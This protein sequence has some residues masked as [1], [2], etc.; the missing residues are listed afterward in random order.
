MVLVQHLIYCQ[1]T[2]ITQS[3]KIMEWFL[4]DHNEQDI[5]NFE[6]T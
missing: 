6:N 1:Y 2:P 4:V 5:E 3:F